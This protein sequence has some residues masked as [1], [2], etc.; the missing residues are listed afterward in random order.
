MKFWSNKTFA[1]AMIQAIFGV[2]V[3]AV[4][5]G[6]AALAVRYWDTECRLTTNNADA[7]ENTLGDVMRLS[8]APQPAKASLIDRIKRFFRPDEPE[9]TF[10]VGG[11][12]DVKVFEG[13][14]QIRVLSYE[15]N[16]MYPPFSIVGAGQTI[17]HPPNP[18]PA[19]CHIPPAATPSPTSG[20][21][22]CSTSPCAQATP[23]PTPSELAPTKLEEY[24]KNSGGTKYVS[25]L[26]RVGALKVGDKNLTEFWA[27]GFVIADHVFAT[28]CH[29]MEPLF[30]KGEYGTPKPGDDGKYKVSENTQL[31]VDFGIGQVIPDPNADNNLISAT[32]EDCSDQEGLD[33]A[34]L[35]LDAKADVPPP[36]TIFYDEDFADKVSGKPAVLITY[37]D[38]SHPVDEITSEMYASFVNQDVSAGQYWAYRKFVMWEGIIGTAH[39]KNIDYLLNTASTTVGSSGSPVMAVFPASG[40]SQSNALPDPLKEPLAIGVHK[41]CAA[42]FGEE[43]AYQSLPAIPCAKLHRSPFNQ[44]VSS[45]SILEEPR[46]C[47]LLNGHNVQIEDY[48]GKPYHLE[49][50]ARAVAVKKGSK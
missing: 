13:R 11:Q 41:C 48:D 3:L 16:C 28:S 29:A 12:S 14:E 46:F 23:S 34:L 5:G 21:P 49:C 40:S 35:S 19:Y 18:L 43:E 22:D 32:F 24:L 37:G 33:V 7:Q 9:Q 20:K 42:Y 25:D 10:F 27:S 50:S 38:L 44:D 36:V 26:Q 30:E 45:K 39:C 2:G 15:V 6:G 17:G 4:V 1:Q 47:K 8:F 31:W